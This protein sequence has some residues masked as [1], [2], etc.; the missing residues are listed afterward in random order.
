MGGSRA[1]STTPAAD[2]RKNN[3]KQKKQ[4]NN[5]I[6]YVEDLRVGQFEV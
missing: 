4:T 2:K 6:E 3:T 5:T 1:Q